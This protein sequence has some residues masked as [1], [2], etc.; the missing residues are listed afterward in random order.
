[1]ITPE[2]YD[3]KSYD[4]LTK[5]NKLSKSTVEKRLSKSKENK[6]QKSLNHFVHVCFQ[7]APDNLLT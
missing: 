7:S 6:Y 3:M 1:M 4:Q 5:C 2:L